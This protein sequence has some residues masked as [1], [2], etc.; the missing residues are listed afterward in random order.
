VEYKAVDL[1][2]NL[3]RMEVKSV[4]GGREEILVKGFKD[5]DIEEKQ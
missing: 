5:S 2:E 4:G 3:S 1:R